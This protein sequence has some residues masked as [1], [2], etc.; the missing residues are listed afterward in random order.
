MIEQ[1]LFFLRRTTCL[2]RQSTRLSPVLWHSRASFSTTSAVC[3]N[4]SQ[5][6]LA[7]SFKAPRIRTLPKRTT[8][9]WANKVLQARLKAFQSNGVL[10]KKAA[11]MG[12][13]GKLHRQLSSDFVTDALAGNVKG[14]DAKAV[15]EGY[16]PYEGIASVDRVLLTSY[17]NYAE[18]RLPEH[19]QESLRSLKQVSDIRYPAEWFPEA[20]QMQRKII[21]HVGPTNS[22]K[23]YHALRH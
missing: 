22:G 21:M 16:N 14:C 19:I 3:R 11:G 13:R 6:R 7:P 23:T 9:S 4:I 1:Y 5:Q 18:P 10:Q 8:L 20:R 12:I 2:V 17:Y 15:L